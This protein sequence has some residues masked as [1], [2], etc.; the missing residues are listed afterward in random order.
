MT[1]RQAAAIFLGCALPRLCAVLLWPADTGTLYYQL[2]NA[3]ATQGPRALGGS[4]AARIEPMYPAFLAAGRMI[5]GDHPLALLLLQIGVGSA[6]G[7][8]LFS[9]TSALTGSRRTAAI[10]ATLYAISPYLVRQSAA[11]MEVTLA[12]SLLIAFVWSVARP[13]SSKTAAATGAILAAAVLTRMSFLPIAAGGLLLLAR[14]GRRQAVAATMAFAALLGAWI[15]IARAAGGSPF[16][17]RIGENLLVSTS[18]WT[19]AIVPQTNVDVLLPVVDAR[20]RETL[21]RRGSLDP[22]AGQIDGVMLE[23][24]LAFARSHPGDALLLKLRNAV[25]AVLPRLL[26]HTERRGSAEVVGGVLVVPPQARRPLAFELAAGGF[27][28]MLLAGAAAGMWKRRYHLAGTDAG[29]LLVAGSV[30]AVNIAFFPTSRL[31]AP[32]TFVLMFYTA[33]AWPER[34]R[35]QRRGRHGR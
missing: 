10:A 13:Q 16:P 20:A 1:R 7:I 4:L 15:G 33:E 24:A 14:A 30:L 32:M 11:F 18:E 31:L 35:E 17:A 12:V 26:P 3:I 21:R 5:G 8:L 27:Q 9:L 6:A 22:S 25:Y 19:R 29:L 23:D 2:A 28:A 34:R